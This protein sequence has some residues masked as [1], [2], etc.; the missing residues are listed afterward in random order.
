MELVKTMHALRQPSYALGSNFGLKSGRLRGHFAVGE[1][2][3]GLDPSCVRRARVFKARGRTR[4]RYP[5][6]LVLS[7]LVVS[8]IHYQALAYCSV[9]GWHT[10]L[11]GSTL[12][13]PSSCHG[14]FRVKRIKQGAVVDAR[15][16]EPSCGVV[17]PF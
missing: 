14:V 10:L 2:S 8:V 13:R 4:Q 7:L 15:E 1:G 16:D 5:S 3:V 11:S 12:A 17:W 9:A 6:R